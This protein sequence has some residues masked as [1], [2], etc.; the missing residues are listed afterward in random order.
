[1]TQ[2]DSDHQ[3]HFALDQLYKAEPP[4]VERT[5]RRLGEAAEGW[6]NAIWVGSLSDS[7]VGA[8]QIAIGPEGVVAIE[9]TDDREMFTADLELIH[10]PPVLQ[11]DSRL[12]SVSH[13]LREY[14]GG[15][16][17][18][19][20]LATDLRGLTEFQRQVLRVTGQVPHGQ[21]LTYGEVARRVGRP[22]AARAVGQALGRN[23]IPIV[24]PCHRVVGAD[25]SLTGYSGGAGVETKAKLLQLEG[26]AF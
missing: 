17:H 2:T 12:A 16:R 9:F 1:M 10:G 22:G 14:F 25:G 3:L 20:H 19:F 8:L 7:L 23:P 26:A 15:A 11:S 5:Q 6:K 24:I 13:Q 18:T 21:L 4:D